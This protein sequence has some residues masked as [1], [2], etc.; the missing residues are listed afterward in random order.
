MAKRKERFPG[1]NAKAIEPLNNYFSSGRPTRKER[2][3]WSDWHGGYK[4]EDVFKSYLRR[5]RSLPNNG[6]IEA[7]LKMVPSIARA[8]AS[9]YGHQP[10]KLVRDRKSAWQG[11]RHIIEDLIGSGNEGLLKAVERYHAE[12]GTKFST[13][14]KYSIEKEVRAQAKML[15]SVVWVPERRDTPWS[16]SLSIYDDGANEYSGQADVGGGGIARSAYQLKDE[17]L[18][19]DHADQTFHF[20]RLGVWELS[21]ARENPHANLPDWSAVAE[22]IDSVDRENAAASGRKV[23]IENGQLNPRRYIDWRELP[24]ETA[25]SIALWR[26]GEMERGDIEPEAYRLQQR[27]L[28]E[29]PPEKKTRWRQRKGLPGLWDPRVMF[30]RTPLIAALWT[31][32]DIYPGRIIGSD[33]VIKPRWN[34][35]IP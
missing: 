30:W 26:L 15:R 24:L 23:R 25:N 7:H 11:Y 22:W 29:L 13:A 1:L 32:R 21:A 17:A 9:L 31:F 4:E 6:S 3:E 27:L 12:R 33:K 28:G 18:D 10:S 5:I 34:S 35:T 14:A 2:R 16:V 8:L 19:A 20:E